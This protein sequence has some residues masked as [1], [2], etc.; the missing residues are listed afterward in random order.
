MEKVLDDVRTVAN[1]KRLHDE[2]A[3]AGEEP[4]IDLDLLFLDIL[5]ACALMT[6]ENLQAVIGEEAATRALMMVSLPEEMVPVG[7]L[8]G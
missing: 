5:K 6:A 4:V 3:E 7:G 1:L 2:L 8:D